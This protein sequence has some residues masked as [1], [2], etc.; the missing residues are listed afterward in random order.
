M[1]TRTESLEKL[2]INF[3]EVSINDVALVGGKNASLGELLLITKNKG[4]KVPPGFALTSLAYWDFIYENKLNEPLQKLFEKLDRKNFKNL[5]TISDTARKLVL[6]SKLPEQVVKQFRLNYLEMQEK[7]GKNCSVAVRSSATAEDL[8]EASFAGQHDSYLNVKGAKDI[9]DAI[10]NCYASLFNQR[11]I[12]YREDKGFEHLKIALSV[13]IQRMVRSDLGSAGVCF[14]IEPES[15]FKDVIHIAGSW[16]LGENV[17]KGSVNPDEFLLFKKTLLQGKD[18]IISRKLGSKEFTMRYADRSDHQPGATTININTDEKQRNKFV[19]TDDEILKLGSWAHTIESHYKKPMD[20][21]WAKDGQTKEI[22]IVQARPETVHSFK[23]GNV[24]TIYTLKSK[25][26][27]ITSGIAIGSKITSGKARILKSPSEADQFKE[28]E[29]LVTQITNPDWNVV[30]KKAAAIITEKGGRTSHASIVARELGLPA[31]IGT[32]NATSKINDGQIITVSCAEG[33]TG[34]VY[35]GM[36]KWDE[37][38]ID[39]EKI[40]M[41]KTQVMLIASDPENAFNLS[42]YPNNGV[43]L[44]RLEFIISNSIRIHPMALVNFKSLKD[45]KAKSIIEEITNQYKDKKEYFIDKL[46]QAVGTIAA[47]FYPK[48]VIVRMSD[49]KSNEYANLIGGKEFEPSEENPMIGFRGASRYYNDRYKE[50]FKLECEAMKRVRD[51]MGL[52]NVK[53]MIP[54]CRTVGE[55]KKV[56]EVMKNFGLNQKDN[57]LEIYMMTEIPSNVLL[58]DEFAKDFD[59]FSIGSNDLTQLTLGI[60]RDSSIISDLFDERNDAAKQLISLA[61]LKAK[62]NKRKIGLCGQAPS[63]FPEYASFLVEQRI[64]SISF[65][66]DALFTGI[67][68]IIKAEKKMKSFKVELV[69]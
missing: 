68:N 3:N 25:A 41:P 51:Q 19:L 37:K 59:G 17:V 24:H 30:M 50:G 34:N 15:G 69:N 28:G 5:E 18:S 7:Y 65:N 64:D 22:F 57:G 9:L 26:E 29:I 55:G 14:T 61:I 62:N 10:L 39:L 52:T 48:D 16:G 2:I 60:D 44:L 63:D 53:L 12:K 13:G 32:E 58:L 40:V 49:F 1:K 47:A 43:G 35:S 66:P 11:A 27:A 38:K 36:L 54:F 46:S 31:V 56:I 45:S 4:I 67:E 20:I 33:Q 6:S 21:E 42:F 23:K 8:P